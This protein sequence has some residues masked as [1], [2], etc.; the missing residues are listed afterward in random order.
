MLMQTDPYSNRA[1]LLPAWPRDWNVK[2]KLHAPQLTTI[3]GEYRDGAMK[4]LKV[5]P[6]SRRADV[7][8]VESPTT[9]N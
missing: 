6:E 7:V 3:E 1:Y 9:A 8:V 2:F 5:V 4:S